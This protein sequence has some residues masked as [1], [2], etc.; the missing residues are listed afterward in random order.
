MNYNLILDYLEYSTTLDSETYL[1]TEEDVNTEL[2]D[3]ETTSTTPTTTST[4]KSIKNVTKTAEKVNNPITVTE[5]N[6]IKTDIIRQHVTSTVKITSTAR[7][8]NAVPITK[9]TRVV[10]IVV[11]KQNKT[12]VEQKR[13]IIKNITDTKAKSKEVVISK[14]KITKPTV[15]TNDVATSAKIK[16]TKP[17]IIKHSSSDTVS[18]EVNV[19]L[20]KT[21]TKATYLNRNNVTANIKVINFHADGITSKPSIVIDKESNVITRVLETKQRENGNT[22]SNVLLIGSIAII[23]T[24][25]L[26]SLTILIYK[27]CKITN[28]ING[29]NIARRKNT[30]E[31]DIRY[32]TSDEAL[33][34]RLALL[35]DDYDEM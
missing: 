22:S 15:I 33:D 21:T 8:N 35:Q 32:L 34:F 24:I 10:P 19:K 11:I 2:Y 31:S 1:T 20:T 12:N 23:G 28:Y 27:K 7:S 14:T 3:E 16:P 25:V 29:K 26:L 18:N 9:T 13:P 6:W 4:M 30:S 17:S 5:S